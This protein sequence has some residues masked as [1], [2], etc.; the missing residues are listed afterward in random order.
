MRGVGLNTMRGI[1]LFT[2]CLVVSSAGMHVCRTD[3]V[4]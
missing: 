4:S 2:C 1:V 3:M